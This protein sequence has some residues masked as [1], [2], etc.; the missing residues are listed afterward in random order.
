M[1]TKEALIYFKFIRKI[2]TRLYYSFNEFEIMEQPKEDI[3]TKN[4]N[5][6]NSPKCLLVVKNKQKI[7]RNERCEVTGKKFKTGFIVL[8]NKITPKQNTSN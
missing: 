2:E 3:N 7:S 4:I 1:N 8:N 5:N 6:L